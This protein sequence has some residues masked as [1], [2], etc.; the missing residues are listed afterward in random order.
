[1]AKV[2]QRTVI[3]IKV[4]TTQGTAV[5]FSPTTD[6]ILASDVQVDPNPDMILRDYQRAT[7]SAMSSLVGKRWVQVSF[8]TP[9]K[10]SGVA[11]TA[12]APLSAALQ[13]CGLLET[14]TGG[15]SCVYAPTSVP[16]SANFYGAGKSCT[17]NVVY[18]GI[19]WTIAGCMGD[20]KLS[21]E[22]GKPAMYE[23]TFKGIYAEPV[24]A[25]MPG[26]TYLSAVEPTFI[27]GAVTVQALSAVL[28]KVELAFGNTLAQR[29]SASA[30][31]GILGFQ[32]VDR[33]ATLS[34]DPEMETVAT[35]N[36]LNKLMAGTEGSFTF[37]V[38]ST[39]G[40]IT[41]IAG[42]KLQY[43]DTK[44]GDRGG[45]RIYQVD[46]L[47]NQSSADDEYSISQT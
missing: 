21:A 3:G 20:C 8:K 32:I 47:L 28:T 13:A 30:A 17:I 36:F 38:G 6:Y 22:A 39:A 29:D 31:A 25:S 35:H 27:N 43:K 23:F 12:Y 46:C 14:V 44:P 18:D 5:S 19:S 33:R 1:M 42:P 15:T 16:V 45:L 37:Q 9:V 26:I 24:D 34:F 41:T 11:G 40:Q 10:T 7:L 2:T 4:E